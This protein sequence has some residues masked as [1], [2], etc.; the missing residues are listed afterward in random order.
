M[1]LKNPSIPLVDFG[2]NISKY[3]VLEVFFLVGFY[4]VFNS[5]A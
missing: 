5:K 3:L 4:N 2:V 1:V